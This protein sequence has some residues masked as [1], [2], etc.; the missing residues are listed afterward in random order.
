[1]VRN[2]RSSLACACV[3]ALCACLTAAP[4]MADSA[5][6]QWNMSGSW[7]LTQSNGSEVLMK[8]RQTG[9]HIQGVAEYSGYNNETHKVQTV[10]GPVDG[11]FENNRILTVT[12]YWSDSTAGLYVGRVEPDG[13]MT[14]STHEQDDPGNKADFRAHGYPI[15]MSRQAPPPAPPAPVALGRVAPSP[16][17][18]GRVGTRDPTTPSIPICDAARSAKARNSPAAPGLEEQCLAGGGSM[19]PLPPSPTSPPKPLPAAPDQLDE[20]AAI[21]RAIAEQ[22]V[23]AARA[24]SAE[25][26][27]FFE[28]GFDIASGLFGDPALGAAG[29][30]LMGPGSERIR[31]SLSATGQRGFDASMAFHQARDYNR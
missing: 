30:K 8:I 17:G 11:T 31:N 1:M 9:T 2:Q 23:A 18:L 22:D 4:A 5:C 19:A 24:R 15:C 10:G 12:V 26:G 7:H 16:K 27:A 3:L 21:G 25:D 14:G 6:L 13:G 29:N 20:L 28:L